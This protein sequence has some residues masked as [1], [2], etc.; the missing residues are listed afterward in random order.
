MTRPLLHD[1]H[2]SSAAYRVRIALHLKQVDYDRH[3]VNLLAG[4][5]LAAEYR[6][7]NPQGQVPCLE[8]DG[9]RLVQS[10][11]IIDYLDARY[12]QPPL[13]PRDPAR[14]AHVLAMALVI[15]CDIHPINNLRVRHYLERELGQGQ[16]AR[17]AWYAKWIIEGLGALE[18]LAAPGAGDW[19]S[20]DQPSLAD[21]CLIPQ[22]FNARR[23]NVPLDAVPTL[24]RV[25]ST[26][27]GH[28]AFAAA[29]PK[30]IAKLDGVG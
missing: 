30:R 24:L 3:V 11:A 20:G 19:L 23:F 2:F 21:I 9:H 26:A 7:L 10:L 5:Q 13:V 27:R 15:A 25:E 4:D 14:R 6:A 28:S 17:D 22:M 12:E 8:I 16:E 1:Y 18:A 29:H